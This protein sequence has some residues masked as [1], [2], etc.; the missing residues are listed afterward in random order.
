[1]ANIVLTGD[2]SGAITIAAPAAAGSNTLTLP[3]STGTMLTTTGSGASLTGID[4]IGLG[5]TYTDVTASRALGVTYTNSTSAP[6]F[7]S[8]QPNTATVSAF[9][10]TVAGNL[11]WVSNSTASDTGNN[12]VGIVPA[13]ATYNI[14]KT[15]GTAVIISWRELR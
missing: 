10:L 15:T 5:Q 7:V 2:T 8:M 9:E 11:A 12:P 13:G 1:M 14:T 4:R 3:A 6:I